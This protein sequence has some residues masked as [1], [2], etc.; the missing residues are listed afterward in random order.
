MIFFNLN[1]QTENYTNALQIIQTE[2]F[3][4]YTHETDTFVTNPNNAEIFSNFHFS[5]VPSIDNYSCNYDIKIVF[6]LTGS[7]TVDSR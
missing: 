1:I 2:F 6:Y 7:K 4:V 3:F 5:Y